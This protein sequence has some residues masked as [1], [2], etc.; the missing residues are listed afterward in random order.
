MKRGLL[1]LALGVAGAVAAYCCF[2]LTGTATSRGWLRS[3]EPELAWLRHEFRLSDAEFDRVARLH[4]GYRPRCQER[5]R[6]IEAL[7]RQLA[8]QLAGA[9]QLTP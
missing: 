9:T 6:Q 1:I 2:Y 4:A 5:C 8:D 7:N 3:P